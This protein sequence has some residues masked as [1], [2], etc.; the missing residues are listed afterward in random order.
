[1][2]SAGFHPPNSFSQEIPVEIASVLTAYAMSPSTTFAI[3]PS[4]FSS[5]SSAVSSSSFPILVFIALPVLLLR[6][7]AALPGSA[8]FR[9]V[10]GACWL[11]SQCPV[12][13]VPI[14]AVAFWVGGVPPVTCLPFSSLN[15]AF[16]TMDLNRRCLVQRVSFATGSFK[17]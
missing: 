4:S 1:M 12:G 5:C 14:A 6:R 13:A 10:F 8:F 9:G 15:P 17:I 3:P 11:L 2:Q 16:S 7:L